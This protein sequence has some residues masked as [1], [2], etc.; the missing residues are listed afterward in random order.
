M[1]HPSLP[2]KGEGTRTRTGRRLALLITPALLALGLALPSAAPAASAQS[3]LLTNGDFAAGSTAGWTC[4][5]GDTVVTSPV[6]PGSSFAL[7]GTPSSSDDAQCSQ[8]V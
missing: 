3:N 6:D 8:V 1:R 7:A 4:S 2:G 5:S